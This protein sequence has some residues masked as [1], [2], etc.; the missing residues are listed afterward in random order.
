M[1]CAVSGCFD[2]GS[3][4]SDDIILDKVI[5]FVYITIVVGA[6]WRF[7]LGTIRGKVH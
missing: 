3:V 6:D 7:T 1:G 2:S 5:V 4:V